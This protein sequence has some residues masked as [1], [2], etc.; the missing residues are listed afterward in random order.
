MS[1]ERDLR[2]LLATMTPE[3]VDGQ[4]VFAA[5][6]GPISTALATVVEDEGLSV[7]LSRADADRLGVPYGFVAAWITLRVH[8][9]LDAVGLTAA[10]SRVLTQ[11]GISCNVIAGFH[12]DHLLVPDERADEAL[13]LLRGLSSPVQRLEPADFDEAEP[14]LA[15]LLLDSVA[16]GASIG[17]LEAT[18]PAEAQAFWRSSLR[19][20]GTVTWVG[21]GPSG[22]VLGCVQLKLVGNPNGRH[23]ADVA[24]LLVHRSA[25]GAGLA[26]ELMAALEAEARRQGRS[27]LVLDT[28]TGSPAETIYARWGWTQFGVLDG[29]AAT[30]DGVLRP[31]TYMAKR[32]T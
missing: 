29:H 27:L 26:G 19:G 21:R 12:H 10:V 32:L 7:V 8:S 24:K 16:D 4:F 22:A 5:T 17:F 3:R 20:P 30:P 15:D 14:E 28:Q 13:T 23:R 18:T 1:G 11:A 31:T 2:T 25:R 6:P 9:A